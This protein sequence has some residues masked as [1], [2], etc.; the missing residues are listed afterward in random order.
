[1]G[2]EGD[3]VAVLLAAGG[4]TRL[5][6]PKQLLTRD[7]E[8]LV[9]RAARLLL[10]TAPRELVIVLGA[11]R[12][13]VA[14]ALQ[15]VPHRAVLNQAWRDGLAGSLRCAAAAIDAPRVLIAVCDQPTL[16]ADHLRELLAARQCAATLHD[17]RPGVPAVVDAVRWSCARTLAGDRGLGPMLATCEHLAGYQFPDLRFDIDTADDVETARREGWLD[18]ED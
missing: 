13:A 18:R 1:M 10:E 5:G 15:G 8:P 3:H 4:S 17:G 16:R 12:D 11:H 14:A 9:L 6:R 2:S 7:G